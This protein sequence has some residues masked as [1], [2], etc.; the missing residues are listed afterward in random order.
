[1]KK[2]CAMFRRLAVSAL[3]FLCL[4]ATALLS[5]CGEDIA[6]KTLKPAYDE[7]GTAIL[8]ADVAPSV[9]SFSFVSELTCGRG[10]TYTVSADPYGAAYANY[11][12][13]TVPL[14]YGDNLVY[15]IVKKDGNVIENHTVNIYR[16]RY[17][18]VAFVSAE[19]TGGY[20][21]VEAQSVTEGDRL[22]PPE[23]PERPGYD[24]LGWAVSLVDEDTYRWVDS[25]VPYDFSYSLAKEDIHT[26]GTSL[27][28]LYYQARFNAIWKARTD[29][30][31]KVEHYTEDTNG[32]Y[33]LAL[34]EEFTG[35]TDSTVS[36]KSKTWTA[37]HLKRDSDHPLQESAA[38]LAGDG[39]TVLKLY[40]SL[41]RV[42]LGVQYEGTG[43]L[44]RSGEYRYGA[45]EFSVTATPA[46]GFTF[47]GWYNKA[48]E[49]VSS[50][51]T[52]TYKCREDITARF[53]PDTDLDANDY[54]I[55]NGT[56]ITGVKDTRA[57]ALVIPDGVTAI[58]AY[59]FS[60][61][62]SLRRIYIPASVKTIENYA[63]LGCSSYLTAY[64][65]AASK[66]SGWGYDWTLRNTEYSY[67]GGTKKY[68]LTV[69]WGVVFK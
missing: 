13:G 27:D 29:T 64:C 52:Y 56:T 68:H 7:S 31:Y 58:A 42:T 47:A 38:K 66:P 20:T 50:K 28:D 2:A 59:A 62:T 24:F 9:T 34:T 37:K 8:R 41:E 36:A 21:T 48:G 6:Y 12:S 22:T 43:T 55:M 10:V 67:Y 14:S 39:T 33:T 16:K 11:E 15:L 45:N 44:S 23:A 53:V 57:T 40:Y 65:E 5:S 51:T 35:K 32:K 54:F 26:G 49:K 1:M 3:L 18:E 63:F 25:T 17:V 4:A 46:A 60:D 69:E 61:C 30:P 19:S